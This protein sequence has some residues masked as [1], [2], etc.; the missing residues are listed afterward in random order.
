MRGRDLIAA[1]ALLT[2]SAVLACRP[3]APPVAP[4]EPAPAA[5]PEPTRPT[6][7]ETPGRTAPATPARVRPVVSAEAPPLAREFRGV[8][9]AS[10]ANIDWPSK[11]SLSTAEQQAE[12]I[13]LLDRAAALKLNAVLFQIRPAADALYASKIEPWSEY[14][15]GAQ[16]RAPVP[17][18]DP[19]EFA[20]KEAHARNLELHAWFNP[21]RARHTDA[22]SPLSST[23]IARTNPSLVKPYAG[24]LWMDPGEPAV[25]ARTLRVVLDVVKRYDVDGVHIDDYFYPYPENDRR[26]RAIPFPDDR[27]WKRYVREGGD[28]S[29]ADWRRRNVDLLVEALDDG[30][31]KTKPWV[32]FG[33]SPFGIWRPGYPT[34]VRGFD[35]YE[36]LY[37]DARKWLREGWV[38][39]FTPQLYW[40][41]TK[42]EQAY[43]ALLDWW[44]GENVMGRHMWP[45][46]FTSR[47][48]GVGSGAFSVGELVEQIRVTRL[49]E[50]ATGN[51]HFSMK[52]FLTN[53]AG[54]NDTLLVGPYAAP[55]L[56][57]ATPWLEAAA[58]PLPTARLSETS[59]GTRLLLRT[60]GTAVP[61]QYAIRLRTDTAWITMLVAGSTTS[62]AIPKGTTPTALSIVSLNRV[63]TE[64]LPVTVT[65]RGRS[66][67]P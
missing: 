60:T 57:P 52:S 41:T 46:N 19:L 48:G 17:F 6:P 49:Q 54:M 7:V 21:Y 65:F 11:R 59:T 30:V 66:D 45:G 14:L 32:R 2:V 18:W 53:Q 3:S 28:L 56:V 15:T 25:R 39:Y 47:A 44:V 38:D 37:A 22:K 16:G 51:V 34:Q 10:V 64:S 43:P 4:G 50:G 67:A 62:W 61:W 20:V 24:Y 8:W 23:H 40:P 33:I 27:S 55:A 58:P 35:A 36:K 9:V 1:G 42:R 26:G 13:A 31:H 12:L 29:R 63:G 5:R